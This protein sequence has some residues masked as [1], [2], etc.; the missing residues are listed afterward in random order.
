MASILWWPAYKLEIKGLR[1]SLEKNAVLLKSI[2]VV[3]MEPRDQ[4]TWS[5]KTVQHYRGD[6]DLILPITFPI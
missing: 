2:L 3:K 5:P 6:T 1:L 4:A